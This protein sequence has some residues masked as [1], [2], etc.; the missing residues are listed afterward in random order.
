MAQEAFDLAE[1]FQTPVFVMIDLDLGMNNWMS[2]RSS[3]R[4]SRSTA[5]SV[6]TRRNLEQ[7][8]E[9]GRYND[10]DGDGIPYRT[11]PGDGMPSY[12]HARLRPQRKGPYSER[13]DDYATT[14]IGSSRKFETARKFV[15]KPEVDAIRRRRSASSPTAR[16][17]GPSRRAAT[18]FA[19][20][21][22]RD[23]L[24]PAARLSVHRRHRRSSST[25]TNASTSSS[26][27]ATGRSAAAEARSQPDALRQAAQRTALQRTADRRPS[28]TD[29]V[30]AQEG[31][32]VAQKDRDAQDARRTT[33]A[34]QANNSY[35]IQTQSH[36]TG[37]HQLYK[38]GKTT[39]C[40]GCGHN[41]ITERIIDAFFEMGVE[42]EP[43]RSSCRA[44]AAR[45]R[46][47]RTSSAA[48]TASTP[49]TDAC[50]RWHRRDA[51][52]QKLI[53][54]GISG[55]GDTG[56]IGIGQFVH[57]MRR[58]LP[59]IYII[60][61]NGCYGLTKGQFSATADVGS[62]LKTGVINDLPPIDYCALAIELGATSSRRRSPATRSSWCAPE[63]RDRAHGTV[64]LDVISPCVTF[65]DHDG[66]TKSYAYSKDHDEPLQ[67]VGFVPSFEDIEIDY[68]PGTMREVTLHDGSKLYLKKLEDVYDPDRQNQRAEAPAR[69]GPARRVRDR[70]DLH[71]AR[72]RRFHHS[73]STSSTSRSLSLPL[74]RVRPGREA[75]EEIMEGLR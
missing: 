69:D 68:E 52:E 43:G 26:R 28:I 25:R 34:E 19:K 66:S 58:N 54:I 44:S 17:T 32:E 59:I 33:S 31:F 70:P 48:R 2:D 18:S 20:R 67:D 36:R 74:D 1:L 4:T 41:A 38:G 8:G 60:E 72:S 10:V 57:L 7:L 3:I 12:L 42:P 9:W 21:R 64:M 16:R 71:R 30:L 65:N 49:C 51:R 22:S 40:A 24:L 75:L 73:S 6:L 37:I 62:K 46:A 35:G 45:A 29:D 53:A 15:P 39:L 13:P 5:A 11:V 56:A 47:R 14:W 50:P 63:S 55:D 27:I 61:D 23:D